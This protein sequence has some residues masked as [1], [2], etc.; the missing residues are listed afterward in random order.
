[1]RVETRTERTESGSGII[2]VALALDVTG[3]MR[4][5]ISGQSGQWAQGE[6]SRMTIVKRAAQDLIDILTATGS[7]VAIGVV[8]WDFRVRLDAAMRTRWEDN[9]Y[10]HYPTRRYYQ[11][12]YKASTQGEWQTLP[13]TK[14]EA[15]SGCLDQRAISGDNP[16]GLSAALP[17][18]TPSATESFVMAFYTPMFSLYNNR[19]SNNRSDH[20]TVA[21]EC[22]G[23]DP[24]DSSQQDICYSDAT[25]WSHRSPQYECRTVSTSSYYTPAIMP[26][27]TDI[28]A[29]KNKIQSLQTK[30]MA[31]NSTLG[32]AWGHR[33]LASSWRTVWG[34]ATTHPVDQ[35]EG[36]QKA[37]VLLTDGE[38][39]YPDTAGNVGADGF[40]EGK[41]VIADR[42]NQACTAAKNAGIKVFTIAAMK[43]S[44]VGDLGDALTKCSSQADDPDGNVRVHQQR[45]RPRTW[46]T[47]FG[48]LPGSW[49]DSGASIK[50]TYE[51]RRR[52]GG[53][54]RRLLQDGLKTRC[55]PEP[56]IY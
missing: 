54:S 42:R 8:P 4:Q 48:R 19:P 17:A 24:H 21:Y 7:P 12:P 55:G 53:G 3:S 44:R 56:R 5:T 31:T 22:H 38:D 41:K 51:K 50:R 6:D 36:V 39:N 14:P 33:L 32:V 37:L 34:A 49:S 16:P 2:E 52:G 45:P 11:N 40:S 20:R 30:G 25:Y 27:T 23:D 18:T 10:A 46:R 15:W 26:L 35:A 28:A 9:S 13:A 1:M 47:R 43:E 29:V